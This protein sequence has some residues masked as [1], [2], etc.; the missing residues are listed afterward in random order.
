MKAGIYTLADCF[1]PTSATRT[2]RPHDKGVWPM[3]Q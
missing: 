3:I 2:H 1:R